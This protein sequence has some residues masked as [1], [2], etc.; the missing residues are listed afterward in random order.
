MTITRKHYLLIAAALIAA[1]LAADLHGGETH[2]EIGAWDAE[3]DGSADGAAEYEPTDGGPDILLEAWNVGE[4]GAIFL[5][6]EGRDD[7]D[8]R[9][10]LIFDVRRTL[11]SKTTY[12]GVPHRLGRNS[13]ESLEAA[14]NHGRLV[15]H[16]DLDPGRSY[17]IDYSDLR[18]RTELQP[19]RSPSFTVGVNYRQQR[20]DG[21]AQALTIAHCDSCH[22]Y[23][24]SRPVDQ[25]T[26]DAG[27]DVL[28]TWASGSLEAGYT[29]RE[30][31]E[32]PNQL[33]LL[34]DD[35]LQ[36]EL[37]IPI[38]DNRLSFDSAQGPQ[39]VH[40]KPDISKD[41]T[42]VELSFPDVGG[43]AVSLDGVLS[44]TENEA[45]GLEADYRGFA[46]NA[47]RQLSTPWR[48]RWR[49][50]TYTLD[51][52]SIFIDI[53][54]PVSIAGPHNGR[55]YREVYGFDPDYL[56][57][58]SLDRDVFESRLEA[59][60]RFSKKAGTLRLLW[61]HET[62]DRDHFEVAVGETKTTENVFG[63]A[64]RAR[65]KKGMTLRAAWRH[66]EVDQ[67]FAN[68]NGAFSTLVSPRVSSPFAPNA[69]QYF[70][71]HRA[72]IADPSAAPESWDEAK[73][74]F[75]YAADG[76]QSLLSASYR[77]WSGENESGDLNDWSRDSQSAT[78]SYWAQPAESWQW[79]LAYTYQESELIFPIAI[80][81]FDG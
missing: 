18:H 25:K 35:A 1:L 5:D 74:H 56:R 80:P 21:H 69:A 55:T 64:W 2:L 76:G 43:F 17:D 15:W 13:L 39:P 63:L 47:V 37:R 50:R 67:P 41:I 24:Q 20:R 66:G 65:P 28:L 51:N 12:V 61:D 49:A 8:Q 72:R 38:F 14:T 48:L 58:S 19:M 27:F 79:S 7:S 34:F 6:L 23:S 45:T 75:A 42:K 31:T 52:D 57:L 36:P 11:R 22:V 40:G 71:F 29:H 16:T 77:Y 30:L 33:E 9:H 53:V 32:S 10:S 78:L 62:V 68:V 73:L 70:D 60:Y 26:E 46:L 54:E 44:T 59:S 4:N 3:V 81:I